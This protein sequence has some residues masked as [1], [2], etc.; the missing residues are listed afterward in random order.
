ME[1]IG[2]KD[3]VKHTLLIFLL[4]FLTHVNTQAESISHWPWLLCTLSPCLLNICATMNLPSDALQVSKHPAGFIPILPTIL[5]ITEQY[6]TPHS[7]IGLVGSNRALMHCV[8]SCSPGTVWLQIVII[9]VSFIL[10]LYD[11]SSAENQRWISEGNSV[12]FFP[13]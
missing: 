7:L 8:G 11:L 9:Y 6:R 3:F 4:Y 5:T 13:I 12:H 10:T 1:Q 2:Q